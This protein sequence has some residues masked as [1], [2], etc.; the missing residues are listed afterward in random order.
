MRL[1]IV[2]T[3]AFALAACARRGPP[4]GWYGFSNA[5]NTDR[6]RELHA[7]QS[8]FTRIPATGTFDALC[9][10]IGKKC[11]KAVD[12]EDHPQACATAANDGSRIAYCAG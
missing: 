4:D 3:L 12:W 10:S 11:V 9:R 2:A 8:Q 1:L 7:I 6:E 5:P